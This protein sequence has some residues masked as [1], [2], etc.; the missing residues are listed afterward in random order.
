M[1]LPSPSQF[2]K[3]EGER[4]LLVLHKHWFTLTGSLLKFFLFFIL[5]LFLFSF[6]FSLSYLFSSFF[7]TILFLGWLLVGVSYFLYEWIVWYYDI[8]I[9]T[10]KR[11]IDIEQ[12]SLFYRIVSEASLDKIQD[13]TYQIEGPTATFFNFGTVKV[14]TAGAQ[15]MIS[16]D[17]VSNPEGVVSKINEA[18]KIF[19]EE[20]G[21]AVTA[22]EL[23]EAIKKGRKKKE[24]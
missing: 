23:L 1:K 15:E 21:G 4:N 10:N 6:I 19:E 7:W 24:T 2:T 20:E 13:V 3:K 12:K 18:L 16:F 11:I 14:Q 22:E 5:P 9:I 17:G 8:Y